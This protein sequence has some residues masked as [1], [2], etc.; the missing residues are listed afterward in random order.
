MF[1]VRKYH[2]SVINNPRN[3]VRVISMIRHAIM[4]DDRPIYSTI[5]TRPGIVATRQKYALPR[6]FACKML[7]SSSRVTPQIRGR[8]IPEEA[9]DVVSLGF[10]FFKRFPLNGAGM[11]IY[12]L[13]N[14]YDTPRVRACGKRRYNVCTLVTYVCTRVLAGEWKY[15]GILRKCG[16]IDAHRAA[17]SE[18]LIARYTHAERILVLRSAGNPNYLPKRFI[19]QGRG[20]VRAIYSRRNKVTFEKDIR[21][22]VNRLNVCTRRYSFWYFRFKDNNEPQ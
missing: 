15:F 7:V 14:I 10:S 5:S 19:R 18:T 13:M 2:A 12:G 6:G 4:A 16:G 11:N 22:P 17:I 9:R 20:E 1:T 8:Y 21:F 3:S